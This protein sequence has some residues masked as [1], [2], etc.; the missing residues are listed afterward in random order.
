MILR[1]SVN[2]RQLFACLHAF[3]IILFQQIVFHAVNQ[4]IIVEPG[5]VLGYQILRSYAIIYCIRRVLGML[6]GSHHQGL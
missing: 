4:A 1:I 3:G 5:I 2:I 6:S